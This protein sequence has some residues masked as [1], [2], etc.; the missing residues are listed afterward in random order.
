MRTYQRL[1]VI[2]KLDYLFPWPI[3]MLAMHYPYFGSVHICLHVRLCMCVTSQD[4]SFQTTEI[5]FRWLNRKEFVEDVIR[6]TDGRP[7][8]PN[9]G[10]EPQGRQT[11]SGL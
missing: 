3:V 10:V 2:T 9:I 4:S 11:A 6:L 7:E 1:I 5:D 8:E